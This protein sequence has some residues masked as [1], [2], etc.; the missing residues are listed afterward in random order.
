M[1]GNL[2]FSSKS[3]E[4]ETPQVLFDKLNMEF[5]F[6]LDPAA[7]IQNAKCNRFYT[8]EDDGLMQDW[9]GE[10]VFCNPPYGR[11]LSAWIK[12]CYDESRKPGTTVVM[13]IPARTDIKAFHKYIL[14]N[15]EIRFLKGRLKFINR[16]LPSYREDGDFKTSPAPFPSMVVVMKRHQEHQR[17]F[18]IGR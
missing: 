10:R 2:M 3:N 4:W 11:Q 7:T 1:N 6:T 13:L 15:A 18:L 16:L 9:Q 17:S 5:R 12:K 14:G 8:M